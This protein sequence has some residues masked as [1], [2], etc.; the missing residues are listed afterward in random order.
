MIEVTVPSYC[1]IHGTIT[2]LSMIYV[3][4]SDYAISTNLASF[5]FS[6]TSLSFGYPFMDRLVGIVGPAQAKL[7][8]LERAMVT[9]ANALEMGLITDICDGLDAAVNT[10]PDLINNTSLKTLSRAALVLGQPQELSSRCY[11]DA[12]KRWHLINESANIGKRTANL[13]VE[14]MVTSLISW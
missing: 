9:S 2:S 14:K 5:N 6:D 13:K 1:I 7:L 12:L 4:L 8:R 10:W 3:V 11:E